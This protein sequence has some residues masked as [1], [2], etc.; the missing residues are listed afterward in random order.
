[1]PLNTNNVAHLA[2]VRPQSN[3]DYKRDDEIDLIELCKIIYKRKSLILIIAA[4][5]TMMSVIYSLAVAPVYKADTFFFPPALSDIQ[6][7]NIA[8]F[9]DVE[10][11]SDKRSDKIDIETVYNVFNRNLNS[12]SLQRSFF[13]SNDV[14]QQFKM[15]GVV[16]SSDEKLFQ[17]FSRFI[18]VSRDKKNKDNSSLSV[19]WS[20][21]VIAAQWANDFAYL[22]E[23]ATVNY[24]AMNLKSAVDNRVRDIEYEIASK[25]KI[26]QQRREDKIAVLEEAASIAKSLD[27]HK[28][29]SIYENSQ[30]EGAIGKQNQLL[31]SESLYYR[32]DKALLVEA[33]VLRKRKSDDAFIL[34]LRDLQEELDRLH[35][36]NINQ[37]ELRAAT[38][39]QSAYPPEQHIKPKRTLIVVL[40]AILGLM[41]GVLIA[42]LVN[43][44]HSYRA[45]E[46]AKSS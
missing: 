10:K 33:D 19:E 26:A 4:F 40:G 18:S 15:H 32:G 31:T 3:E 13:D 24:F 36:I 7:L 21:P 12:R 22:A 25:R 44:V 45:N 16:G 27:I 17:K 11:N 35:S 34:D 5:F 23:R 20:D 37:K 43:A 30:K 38:V 29:A 6:A 8:W 42:F 39:D 1:M 28:G 2:C 41:V 46:A 9:Q 14:P